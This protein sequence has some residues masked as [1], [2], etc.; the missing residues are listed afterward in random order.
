MSIEVVQPPVVGTPYPATIFKAVVEDGDYGPQ[1]KLRIVEG[2]GNKSTLY[3][4]LPMTAKNRTGRV[5]TSLLG[6]YPSEAVDES[7]FVG[8][9]VNMIYAVNRKDA[10]KLVIDML[11]PRKP[12]KTEKVA[13]TVNK[14]LEGDDQ[15][16]PF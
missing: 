5:A 1:L 8:M 15:E 3:L 11:T 7:V 9:T 14:A 4:S 2:N 16:A 12:G 10:T 6:S 13:L